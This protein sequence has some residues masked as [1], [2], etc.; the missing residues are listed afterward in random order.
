MLV[1]AAIF[2]WFLPISMTACGLVVAFFV[3]FVFSVISEAIASWR[4]CHSN[5]THTHSD[6]FSSLL[7]DLRFRTEEGWADSGFVPLREDE[8]EEGS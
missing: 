3:G 8:N 7:Q 2:F 5:L 1:L 6:G 4:R